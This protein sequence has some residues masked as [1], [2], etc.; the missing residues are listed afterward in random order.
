MDTSQLSQLLA[1]LLPYLL[2]GGM[3]LAKS[4]AGELG[5]KLSADSWDGLKRL[6][7]KIQQKA[8]AKPALQEALTAAS[9]GLA[10]DHRAPWAY[11][12]V[13]DLAR[14]ATPGCLFMG[15]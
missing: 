1:P 7:E 3:E 10:A 11:A 6:A 13:A 15:G 4:A 5:K 12:G 8:K 14:S 2:K 9:P